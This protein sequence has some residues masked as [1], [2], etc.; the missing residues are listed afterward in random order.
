MKNKP[1]ASALLAIARDTFTTKIFP[2][3]PENLRYVGLMIAN[4]VAI[5]RREIEAGDEAARGELDRL[6]ALFGETPH[7]I[8]S[9]GLHATLAEYN[10]RLARA[11]RAGQFDSGNAALLEH[12][13]KTTEEKLAISNPKALS[14]T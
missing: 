7:A 2:G 5:A 9:G 13:R 1:E 3:L 12:L 4:A 8:D 14:G 10:R 6:C 11:I